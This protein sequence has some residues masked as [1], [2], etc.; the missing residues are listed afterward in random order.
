MC[1]R[2]GGQPSRGQI[3]RHVGP[4]WFERSERKPYLAHDLKV[5]VQR[6]E[7]VFPSAIRQLRPNFP[8]RNSTWGAHRPRGSSALLIGLSTLV[9]TGLGLIRKGTPGAR[10]PPALCW[11]SQNALY[12]QSPPPPQMPHRT[13]PPIPS[14]RPTF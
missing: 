1:H 12:C 14:P 2:R 4:L 3:Q 7:R 10:N 6:G 11:L 8:S 5:H 9:R 13:D